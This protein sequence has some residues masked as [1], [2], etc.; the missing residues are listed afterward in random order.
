MAAKTTNDTR[1]YL[2]YGDDEL[3]RS[4]QLRALLDRICPKEM[5]ALG[6]ET[7]KGECS[8]SDQALAA[9]KQCME[10]LQT[11]GFLGEGKTVWLKDADFLDT[12]P[13]AKAAAVK[14]ALK[15]LGDLAAGL[16]PGC[17]LLISGE[18][19]F[20]GSAFYKQLA[21]FAE[22]HEFKAA[23][24]AAQR[25]EDGR[26]LALELFKRN[27]VKISR[28]VSEA[29]AARC[30]SDSRQVA[31]EVEKLCTYL[32]DRNEVSMDDV[33][34]LTTTTTESEYWELGDSIAKRDR[35][36]ALRLVREQSRGGGSAVG[37]VI[38]IERTLQQLLTVRECIQARLLNTTGNSARWKDDAESLRL[39][40]GI[41]AGGEQDLRKSN[42][43]RVAMLAKDSSRYSRAELRR[44]LGAAVK[45]HEQLVSSSAPE[46]HLIE[47]LI[48][49]VV[50]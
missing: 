10:A 40:D 48:E 29:F 5:Q 39:L 27:G 45:T 34:L 31:Q 15:S 18:K 36:R 33:A 19:V 17:H 8:N 11:V 28:A 20:K 16:G 46:F 26:A 2:V 44:G 35:K 49:K 43:Y 42:S 13:T 30:A 12:S 37:M 32:G 41:F 3:R 14:E 21:K 23:G 6:L 25:S 9:I 7:V 4:E 38:G 47:L 50:G 1:T 22:I 24:R